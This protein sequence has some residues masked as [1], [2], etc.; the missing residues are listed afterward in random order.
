MCGVV[1][2][3][4]QEDVREVEEDANCC[5]YRR[6]EVRPPPISEKD[7]ACLASDIAGLAGAEVI[8]VDIHDVHTGLVEVEDVERERE[9]IGITEKTKRW[10]LNI[11]RM[12]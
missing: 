2:G 11:A 3:E 8:D 5:R 6:Q 10:K 9:V 12:S 1:A 7:K 4:T